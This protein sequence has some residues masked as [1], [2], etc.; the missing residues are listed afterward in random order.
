MP[1]SLGGLPGSRLKMRLKRSGTVSLVAQNQHGN[2]LRHPLTFFLLF[3]LLSVTPEIKQLVA[4]AT[5]R[6]EVQKMASYVVIG[7]AHFGINTAKQ[8]TMVREA[9]ALCDIDTLPVWLG[10]PAKPRTFYK[11]HM[12]FV[13]EYPAVAVFKDDIDP[14]MTSVMASYFGCLPSDLDVA[15]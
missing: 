7:G 13:R 12:V 11:T 5:A 4:E 6:T 1:G 8:M 15:C 10:N 2:F 14:T 9:M 3:L